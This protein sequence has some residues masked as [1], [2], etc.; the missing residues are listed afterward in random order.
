MEV[1]EQTYFN[2]HCEGLPVRVTLIGDGKGKG[3]VATRPIRAGEVVFTE[4]PLVAIQHTAN[5]CKAIVCQNCFTFVG[6]LQLQVDNILGEGH[7]KL[8]VVGDINPNQLISPIFQCIHGCGAIYCSEKCRE[9]AFEEYHALL[10]PREKDNHPWWTLYEFCNE[11]NDVFLL[12][13]RALSKVI[14]R[15]ERNGGDMEAAQQ[16]FQYVWKAPWWEV[17]GQSEE[18]DQEEYL[19]AFHSLVD[20]ATSL[21]RNLLPYKPAYKQIINAEYISKMVGMFEMNNAHLSVS[22]PL[23]DYLLKASELADSMSASD[24]MEIELLVDS[25]TIMLEDE[26]EMANDEADNGKTPLGMGKGKGKQPMSNDAEEEEEEDMF[27]ACEGN[28]LYCIQAC[29]NHSCCPNVALLK[30]ETDLD[31]SVVVRALKDINEGDELC[32]SYIEENDSLE[33]RRAVLK[34]YLFEC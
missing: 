8:P 31:G 32:I 33:T 16:C 25:L 2:T 22:S 4:A 27:F 17:V 14:L 19:A 24:N 1:K 3:V 6:T 12:V 15:Y 20:D 9:K 10:C 30:G 7:V 34:D 28:A 26:K 11:T 21:L 29:L 18:M 23:N 5:R 13:A